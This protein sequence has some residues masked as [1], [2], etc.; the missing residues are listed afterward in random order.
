MGARAERRYAFL[1]GY[2]LRTDAEQAELEALRA[3]VGAGPPDFE[4]EREPIPGD[5]ACMV[6]A[7]LELLDRVTFT[8][9]Q[10]PAIGAEGWPLWQ[11][12]ARGGPKTPSTLAR[13]RQFGGMPML[14]R[15]L[16]AGVIVA[17]VEALSG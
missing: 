12:L 5:N 9:G 15:L 16:R 11:D 3:I 17:H 8:A 1:S 4:V 13:A 10:E 7:A 6:V 14:A 2:A